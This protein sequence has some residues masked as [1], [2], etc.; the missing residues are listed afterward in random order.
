MLG[1]IVLIRLILVLLG[2]DHSSITSSAYMFCC[3][4]HGDLD[5]DGDVD[6]SDLAQLLAHYG[7]Q[8]GATYWMGDLD[9]DGDV[10]MSDLAALLANYGIGA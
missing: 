9:R 1:L 6:L 2:V 10:D 8:S 7:T 3:T 4:S 5:H